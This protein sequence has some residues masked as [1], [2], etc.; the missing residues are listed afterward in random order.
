[1][2]EI[3]VTDILDNSN[4][5]NQR[6][7]EG[8][9]AIVA[10][11]FKQASYSV[12]ITNAD[13]DGREITSIILT[14]M[15]G[16]ALAALLVKV[17]FQAKLTIPFEIVRGYDLPGYVN[18]NTLVIASSYSGN[19]E[20]T[21]SALSQAQH[22]QSQ[23][24]IITAGGQLAEI[25]NQQNIA[26]AS[27]PAGVQPR[28]AMLYN[29]RGLLAILENFGIIGAEVNEQVALL[30]GWLETESSHWLPEVPTTENY[31]KQIA[32]QAIGKTPIFY[33]GALTA[34]LAYK[35]KISW[36]ETAKN[37]AFWN[38][39]SE[40]N[41]NEFMG[42]AS[43][44]VEKPFVVFDLISSFERPRILQ[45][46]ELTDIILSGKRPAAIRIEL[47]GDSPLAHLLWGAILADFA[48]TYAAVLNGV[49][50][51]PVVLIEKLKQQLA[52][53]PR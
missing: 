47:K 18:A 5:L 3:L 32:H 21:L 28:M 35:W 22:K 48:S 8:A 26:L 10:S 44:P 4:V 53:N 51:T 37:V 41:H 24:A 31:A 14:G 13:H 39:Y 38:E 49:D 20:E 46:F 52:D 25:A 23:I 33:G 12:P 42:W 16:S 11:Q 7:P 6:D 45:R 30:S 27:L 34:P 9:L 40:F 17:L 19:T 1:M 29:L 43:H 36:N 2:V 50:P 15:G